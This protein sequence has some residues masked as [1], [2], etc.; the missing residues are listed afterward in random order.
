MYEYIFRAFFSPSISKLA[1]RIYSCVRTGMIHLW[2]HGTILC[3]VMFNFGCL[4]VLL[5]DRTVGSRGWE[6]YCMPQSAW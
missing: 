1:P 4:V 2:Y 3:S 6:A 5:C